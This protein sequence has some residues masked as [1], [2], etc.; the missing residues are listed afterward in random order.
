MLTAEERIELD[1]LRK[2][3]TG[4]RELTRV[5]GWNKY[6]GGQNRRVLRLTPDK[7]DFVS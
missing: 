3:G 5:T 6:G 2:H 1:V 7:T 4:I